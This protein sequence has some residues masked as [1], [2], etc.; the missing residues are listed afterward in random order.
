M[1]AGETAVRADTG[2][3]VM[4]PTSVLMKSPKEPEADVQKSSSQEVRR[5]EAVVASSRAQWSRLP[6]PCP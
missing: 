3:R 1:Y 6:Y 2:L 5:A 4:L